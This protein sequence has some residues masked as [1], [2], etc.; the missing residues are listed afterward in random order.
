MTFAYPSRPLQVVLKASTFFFPAGETTF[1]VGKSGSG[2]S[3]VGDIIMRFYKPNTGFVFIDGTPIEELDINWLRNNVTLVQ[4]QSILFNET[5]S[6][7]IAFGKRDHASVSQEDVKVCIDVAMLQTTIKDLPKGIDTMVGSS[8]CALSG[9]QKQR[10]AIARARLRDT[11]VLILDESTSALDHTTRAAVLEA[12]RDW[13]RGKTTIVITHD[14]SQITDEDFVYVLK[15]GHIAEEGYRHS[16]VNS[17]DGFFSPRLTTPQVA[18][19]AHYDF[20]LAARSTSFRC[21]G[22]KYRSMAS[23]GSKSSIGRRDSLELQLRF[24][25]EDTIYHDSS[26]SSPDDSRDKIVKRRI[27]DRTRAILD[28]ARKSTIMN[29]APLFSQQ[30]KPLRELEQLQAPNARTR[31]F[32]PMSMH[33]SIT[34]Q[35]IYRQSSTRHKSVVDLSLSNRVSAINIGLGP[36]QPVVPSSPTMSVWKVLSTVW[37]T[38]DGRARHF[39]ILGIISTVIHAAAPSCFSYIFAQLLGTFYMRNSRAQKAL[40]YSMAILGIAVTDGAAGF[41]MHYLLEASSQ[42]WI[43]KL[44]IEAMTRILDQPRAWFDHDQNSV[45]RLMSC[46]DRN[47][48]EMRNLVGRFAG[49]IVAIVEMMSISIS[50]SFT[51]CW[52]VTVVAMASAPVLYLITKSFESVSSKWEDLTNDAGDVAEAIFVETFTD[53]RTVRSLT[54]ESYFH[55]KYTRATSGAFQV[56]VKRG[57]VSGFFF[58]A[59]DSAINFVTALIFWYGARLAHSYQFP[60]KSILTVFS[61]LLFSTANA[62]AVLA[63]MPQISSSVDT[64]GRLLRLAKLPL[65][66][67][68]KHSG[69][70]RLN[71]QEQTTLSGPIMFENLT[72]YY[73]SRP[74]APVL[75]NLDLCIPGGACTAIVGASGSGKSTIASLILGL[76]PPSGD[77]DGRATSD[78]SSGVASL[79]LSGR[80]IRSYYLPSLRS[81]ISIVPQTPI[82]FPTS[83]RTNITYGLD[84]IS[85]LTTTANVELAA[86]R[87]GIHD[88]IVT[89]PQKYETAIGDG[90]IGVSGG[91]AQRIVIARALIRKPRILILDE[92]TSALDDENAEIVRQSVLGLVEEARMGLSVVGKGGGMTVIIIT[93][94]QEM[95]ECAEHVVVMDGGRVVREYNP[96]LD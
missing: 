4:Q 35:S 63:W 22:N 7:N 34:T 11:P 33:Q 44:R 19:A 62:N 47:A 46:L 79:T 32:R 83:I 72:F 55:K 61:M 5:I 96:R 73:P 74:E 51:Q 43:D 3:T 41:S 2:K 38:L 80:D 84:L 9:G 70:L 91:Q 90:G 59:S 85:S 58:G 67:S 68:H 39:V 82:L 30:P 93:H 8:G 75:R 13:R 18:T 78:A 20:G 77:L 15:D 36:R 76:Y 24:I 42:A 50:W 40:E 53:I 66:T 10:I 71:P 64:A 27:S 45:P 54:L 56:G 6:K 49:F 12:I 86:Q 28:E 52:K 26:L 65:H 92:A 23:N 69:T 14:M 60:V 16:L 87:A 17:R 31:A 94:S 1:I 37:P 81:M 29:A 57:L 88:F 48:E 21:S 25:S 89:L 95:M